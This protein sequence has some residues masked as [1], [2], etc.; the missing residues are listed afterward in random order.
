[1]AEYAFCVAVPF[2]FKLSI[3]SVN[4]TLMPSLV[5]VTFLIPNVV[6]L[7]TDWGIETILEIIPFPEEFD[8]CFFIFFFA[9]SK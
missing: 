3:R 1:M 4:L 6:R 8:L 7:P 9:I 2:V 5:F